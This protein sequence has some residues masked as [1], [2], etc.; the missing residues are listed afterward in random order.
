MRKSTTAR[1][2]DIATIK[3][4][5]KQIG[6]DDGTYR[7]M[8]WTIARVRSAA[9]LDWTGRK[10]VI[11]HLR[12]IGA[13]IGWASEWAFIDQAAKEKKPLLRKICAVCRAMKVGRVYAEGAARRILALPEGVA[14]HLGMLDHDKLHKVAG[15]LERT[16]LHKAD[17]GVESA[18]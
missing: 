8:L 2:A 5:V 17:G 11:D 18:R 16:R 7:D 9:D 1:N 6:M 10:K 4:A 3:I 14:M 13:K 15:A 12:K